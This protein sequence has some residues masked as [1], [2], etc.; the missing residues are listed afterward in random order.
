MVYVVSL[1][2]CKNL[3][4]YLD[5]EYEA[6]LACKGR[7]EEW[8]CGLL[9][10]GGDTMSFIRQGELTSLKHGNMHSSNFLFVDPL[11]RFHT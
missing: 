8:V 5:R 10:L 6:P 3:G 9:S 1:S 7:K 4:K 2:S 11:F